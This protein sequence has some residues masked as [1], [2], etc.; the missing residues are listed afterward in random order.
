MGRSWRARE[1]KAR[2]GEFLEVSIDEGPRIVTGR[3]VEAAV[4][5][6]I[7]RWRRLR[8][9]AQSDLK[10][11]P[12]APEARIEALAPPRSRHRSRPASALGQGG[13]K[14]PAQIFRSSLAFPPRI[15]S[16]SPFDSVSTE[17]TRPTG[18]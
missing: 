2:F 1:A 14:D 5:L 11:V 16:L 4:P 15:A 17:S 12:L 8:E 18:S 9:T 6:P 13:G 7:G 3:G 10:E